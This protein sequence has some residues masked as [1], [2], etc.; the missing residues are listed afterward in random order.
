M[1]KY[2]ELTFADDFMF[3]KVLTTNPNLCRELL[4]LIIG[5]KVG[6]F[7]RLDQQQPIELTADGKGVRF[8]V[9]SEDDAGTVFDCEMQTTENRNLPKRSRYYQGMIDLNLIERGADYSELKKSY[10][11]FIC[12]FD[13]FGAGLHKYT[14]ESICK[15]SPQINLGD[16]ATKIFLCASGDADDVTPDM[17]DFLDWLSGKQGRSR[18]VGEL[19]DAVQKVKDHK[20]WR[21]EYMTLLMRDQEMMRKGREEGMQQ[22]MR[23][24]TMTTL[25][26]LVED[27]ILTLDDAA[28]RVNM[29]PEEFK[30]AMEKPVSV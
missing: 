19:E 4:E 20:E 5:R 2:E 29:T 25:F 14:F 3:C 23:Q 9:Y 7:T 27:G 24:G 21:T 18:L 13:A 12:P 8:D 26:S 28:S 10:V 11:I 30:E 6:Q 22:G 1:K 17:K 15:E 16:E